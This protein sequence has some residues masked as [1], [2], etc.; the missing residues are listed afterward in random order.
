MHAP[1]T[2]LQ[3]DAY[4]T[5]LI[6]D[7]YSKCRI[8]APERVESREFGVGTF[9]RKII[10]RHI[11]FRDESAIQ[12]YL[13]E[14]AP[15]YVS[16]S[17]AYYRF[18]AGRPMET[19]G[20]TGS[21]LVFDLDVDDIDPKNLACGARHGRSWVC[22]DCLDGV[23]S[24]TLKL[25]E[26][27]LIPDF[28]FSEREIAV[29]FS[30]NRGYHV[31]VG[32]DSI[33]QLG[34]EARK[35]I[36]DYISGNGLSIDEFFPEAARG[37]RLTGPRPDEKGWKGRIARKF[38]STMNKGPDA[39]MA[40][41]ADKSVANN[42]YR[43]RAL[44]EMG[45]NSG[46]WD[47]VYIKNKSEFW[48]SVLGNEAIAQSDRIDGN[49]TKDISHLIRLPDTVHGGTGLVAKRIASVSA[50]AAFDPMASAL[51]FTEGEME[52]NAE[53]GNELVIG[54]KTFGPYKGEKAVLPIYAGVYL[55]LKGLASITTIT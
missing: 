5:G 7:Y 9:E 16:Y 41:G 14:N 30:G 51:A 10:K 20:W 32:K 25:I 12:A 26:E 33:T 17:T 49:V 53:S 38:I 15:A 19:K 44:I 6:R 48:K 37:A 21:E 4:I 11:S 34:P 46:N 36:S 8:H 31:H 29:N 23:K 39:L 40:L 18:P 50:L 3:P 45:I 2:S 22:A 43:K 35:E 52:I 47:M 1:Q 55:Y 54:N 24:E 28:G 27:F 13:S 42:I